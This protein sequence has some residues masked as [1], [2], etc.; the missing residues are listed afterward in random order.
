MANNSFL[1]VDDDQV[2]CDRIV[3]ALHDRGFHAVPAYSYEQ[4][5]AVLEQRIPEYIVLDLR[6]RD[7]KNGLDVLQ[8]IRNR[9]LSSEVLLLTGFGSIPVA[10]RAAR[11]GIVDL[12]QKPAD[13]D[14]ILSAFRLKDEV[15]S[16][17]ENVPIPTLKCVEWEHIQRTLQSTGGNISEASRLLGIPRR[18]LHRKL[19]RTPVTR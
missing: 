13:V 14:S 1:V 12:L 18:S 15:L 16:E 2:L 9:A 4:T 7:G 5:I 17:N 11:L 8:E 10:L 19:L 3:A 6:L